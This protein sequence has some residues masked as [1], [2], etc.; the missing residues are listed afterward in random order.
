MQHTALQRVGKTAGLAATALAYFAAV[1]MFS[2][3][4][5]LN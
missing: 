5:T 1:A 3:L 4:M 2:Y